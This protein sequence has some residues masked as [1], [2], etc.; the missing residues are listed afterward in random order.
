MVYSQKQ[1]QLR[2]FLLRCF[3]A[4]VDPSDTRVGGDSYLTTMAGQVFT[5]G[6][7]SLFSQVCETRFV[8]GQIWHKNGNASFLFFS[9]HTWPE[10]KL[11]R[12]TTTK[13]VIDM[14]CSNGAKFVR[15]QT[16]ESNFRCM[17]IQHR[18]SVHVQR[19]AYTPKKEMLAL[20]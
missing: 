1:L 19:R 4:R 14:N 13:N 15:N 10:V 18:R 7:T 20:I 11:A 16:L 2:M 5:T 12:K 3:V 17:S 9:L 6:F 8:L